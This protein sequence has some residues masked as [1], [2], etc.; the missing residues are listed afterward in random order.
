MYAETFEC[1]CEKP[2]PPPSQR[3]RQRA[4]RKLDTRCPTS[5]T[6]CSLADG[7]ECI[8][9]LTNL[10]QCG[11]CNADVGGMDCTTLR[12]VAGVGCVNGRCEIWACDDEYLFV[13]ES[14]TCVPKT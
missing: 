1:T 7:Y 2:P 14:G 6:A 13:P 4:R 10:E 12:G 11:G 8:D 9:I 5:Y 3:A